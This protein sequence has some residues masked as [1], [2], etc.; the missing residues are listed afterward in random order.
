MT[1][2]MVAKH[3][4][5]AFLLRLIAAVVAADR[6][7][8]PPLLLERDALL[9]FKS[10]LTEQGA[11]TN[12]NRTTH[13]CDFVRVQCDRSRRH[14]TSLMLNSSQIAGPLSPALTN[15]TQLIYLD[16]YDNNLTGS[17]PNEFSSWRLLRYLDLSFNRLVG[18]IPPSLGYISS[19]VYL[20]LPHNNLKDEVPR[21]FFR[22]LSL[23]EFIDL[24]DNALSGQIPSGSEN[25]LPHLSFFNLYLNSLSGALPKWLSNSTDLFLLDVE[26]NHLS[27]E[28]PTEM[29]PHWSHL[30]ILHLSDNDLTSHDNNTNLEPFFLALSNCS[31]LQQLEMG[32]LGVGGS[33]PTTLLNLSVLNLEGNRI[34]GGIPSGISNL[35]SLTLLNLSGNLL[36]GPIPKEIFRLHELERL[37]ISSN[38]LSSSIPA[39]ISNATSLGLVD[40]SGNFL[41]GAIPMS[42]GNLS[43]RL[44]YLYLHNNRLSGSIPSSLGNCVSLMELDLSHNRLTGTIPREISGFLKIFL[45]LSNN[46]LHGH[47]PW[48]LSKMAQVQEIDLSFNNLTGIIIS[49]LS[50]C[51]ELRLLDLSNNDLTG[52][53]PPKLGDLRNLETL[54]VSFNKL[55]GEIPLTLNNCKNLTLL[56]LSNNDFNGSVPTGGVFTNLFYHGNPHLCGPLNRR[57]CR[58]RSRSRKLLAIVAVGASVFAF[59]VTICCVKLIRKIWYLGIRGA[60]NGSS[61]PVVRSNYP[62]I[63]HRELVEATEDF[64]LGRL[65]G[66]GSYG[67]VYRGVLRDGTNVAVKVLN[68]QTG[69]STKSFNRECQVLKRIRHRNLMRIITACSHPDFKAL[70]L[71]FM[72]NGSLESHL[73]NDSCRLSL[74]QRVSICSDIAEGMAYLHH[75][76]PVKVIHCDLKPSN[77]LLNDEMTALVSDFG[78]SRLVTTVGVGN[79]VENM[80]NST[81][82]MLYG[83]IGYIAPEYGYGSNP[84]TKGDVYSFGVLVL[85]VVTRK[86]PTD[87]MFGEGVSLHKW[88]KSHYHGREAMTIDSQLASEVR[89]QAP[90]LRKIWDVGISEMLELG[91]LCTQESASSRPTM[92]D[93]AD[94]LDR[95]KRYLAGDMTATFA[96]SLGMSSSTFGE[97]S[98]SNFGD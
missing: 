8:T 39:E 80:G 72:A 33:L 20:A 77:V 56:D 54:D 34:S 35:S 85:E 73:H 81:V 32:R 71:P 52:Q 76:S 18:T 5:F 57:A 55:D 23:V 86:R 26:N 11:L 40:L 95:L 69:N 1:S 13:V 48:E 24:S 87:E 10:R 82:N 79:T 4:I 6:P 7:L 12:W 70:V 91:L 37:F 42:I 51:Y 88:A 3:A 62:R 41:S 36:R 38:S 60:G 67:R 44:S 22:N 30:Q 93:V 53:L 66:S 49:Q 96:S 98:Q 21:S 27:G 17:I 2:S 15:L 19:L 92:M 28:L 14:V 65:I 45:N 75:H 68:L 43:R 84:S 61:S 97:T 31:S 63:S 29:I 16:L 83:S 89:H 94:D 9:A 46:F 78:I 90:E 58:R 74:A 47:L 25:A 59:V 50:D 64:D